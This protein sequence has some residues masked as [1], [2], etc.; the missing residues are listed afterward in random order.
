LFEKEKKIS[1]TPPKMASFSSAKKLWDRSYT[2]LRKLL[3][4]RISGFF[5]E[6]ETKLFCVPS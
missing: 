1:K 2:L 4:I 6:N 5:L 3:S